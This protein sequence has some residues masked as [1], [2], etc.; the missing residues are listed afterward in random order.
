MKNRLARVSEIIKRELSTIIAR[1]LVFEVPLVTISGVDITPDLKNAHIFL[2][3]I[4]NDHE[5][6]K[7]LSQ[8]QEHR[9]VLQSE[10]SKRVILKYTPHL[11]FRLDQAIERGSRVLAVLDELGLDISPNTKPAPPDPES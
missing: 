2:S 9:V 4:G 8:L 5:R 1:E 10:L 6:S 3:A 7:V 11:H